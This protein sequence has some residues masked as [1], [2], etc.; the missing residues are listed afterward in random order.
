MILIQKIKKI[1]NYRIKL[2]N[3]NKIY[4]YY[5][6]NINSIVIIKIRL[7]T[8]VCNKIINSKKSLKIKNKNI[9]V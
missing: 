1:L 3:Q 6:K 4:H 9:K 8:M 5:N 2:I 7:L